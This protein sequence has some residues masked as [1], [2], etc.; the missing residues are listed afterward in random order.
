MTNIILVLVG[1][2]LL[3][4]VAR[5]VIGEGLALVFDTIVQAMAGN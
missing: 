3:V 1:L 4:G 2:A 5:V